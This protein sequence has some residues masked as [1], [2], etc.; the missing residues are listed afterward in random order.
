[1]GVFAW[2]VKATRLLE[3]FGPSGGH[4]PPSNFFKMVRFGFSLE[5]IFRELLGMCKDF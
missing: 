2:R 3:G 1:M 5:H 4:A